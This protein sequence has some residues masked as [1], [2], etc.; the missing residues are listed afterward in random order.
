MKEI[1]VLKKG[2]YQRRKKMIFSH[3]ILFIYKPTR[4][5][6]SSNSNFQSLK[7]QPIIPRFSVILKAEVQTSPSNHKTLRS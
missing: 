6:I 3:I 4:S 2:F 7:D 1:R 5:P